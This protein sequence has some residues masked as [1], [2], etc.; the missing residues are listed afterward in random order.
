MKEIKDGEEVIVKNEAKPLGTV[1]LSTEYLKRVQEG[2]RE[3]MT[4]GTGKNYTDKTVT[5][6]G[7]TGTSETFIDSDGDGKMDTKTISSSFI[8][9]APFENPKYSIV[10]ISPNISKSDG[11]NS[12]KYAINLKVNRKIVKY[13]FE[14]Q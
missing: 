11:E 2:M 10:I 9:Y 8:M 14:N 13:L 6:A 12:Y 4:I 1:N 5:S 7:K 3:V